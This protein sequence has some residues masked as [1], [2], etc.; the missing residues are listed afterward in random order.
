MI[1]VLQVTLL[2]PHEVRDSGPWE[3]SQG[4]QPLHI[5]ERHLKRG[6]RRCISGGEHIQDS[7][8]GT[9]SQT[10]HI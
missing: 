8:G 9:F 2:V 1:Q 3:D 10:L 5:F 4:T 7:G 6:R